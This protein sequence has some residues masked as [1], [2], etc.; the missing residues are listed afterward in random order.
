LGAYLLTNATA[1]FQ[2]LYVLPHLID[3]KNAAITATNIA[4][5][6]I[7]FRLGF[8]S[9]LLTFS[10][11][12]VLICAIFIVLRPVNRNLALIALL[13]R[14]VETGVM[15]TVVLRSCVV[16]E[17][18]TGP[19][20]QTVTVDQLQALVLST[21]RTQSD[22][23]VIGYLFLGL[24]STLFRLSLAKIGLCAQAH[25]MVGNHRI[26][27][28]WRRFYGVHYSSECCEPRL[29]YPNRSL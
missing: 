13:W 22:Q 14:L 6:Q 20:Q 23:Y 29:V 15:V 5:N 7:L 28:L 1:F 17:F 11:L 8:A 25:G 21:L 26:R 2:N 27:N 10:V 19:Y 4:R 24:G 9:D 3:Y 18:L 12:V 16:L